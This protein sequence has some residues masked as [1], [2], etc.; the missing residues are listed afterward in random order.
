M[1][2]TAVSSGEALALTVPSSVMQT[3]APPRCT[4]MFRMIRRGAPPIASRQNRGGI[5]GQICPCTREQAS[6]HNVEWLNCPI[7][8]TDQPR[9]R[10]WARTSSSISTTWVSVSYRVTIR[11]YSRSSAFEVR[12]YAGAEL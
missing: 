4:L 10:S 1:G 11:A 6:Q 2:S 3:R 7:F 12:P 5:G 9:W 8:V